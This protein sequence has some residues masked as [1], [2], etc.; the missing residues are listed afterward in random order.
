MIKLIVCDMDGTIIGH[1]E[2]IPAAAPAFIRK[3]ESEG[4]MFTIATGRSESV[5]KS[6]I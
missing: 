4:S 5:M 2:K 3:V 6:K 1:D